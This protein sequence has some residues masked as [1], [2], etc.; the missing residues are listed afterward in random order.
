[1]MI[2][3][4]N[5]ETLYAPARHCIAETCVNESWAALVGYGIV[6]RRERRKLNNIALIDENTPLIFQK[7]RFGIS[8]R[9]AL[10]CI[11]LCSSIERFPGPDRCRHVA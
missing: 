9:N 4:N 7:G 3:G 11:H 10:L 6:E 1:M 8:V 2:S 5:P